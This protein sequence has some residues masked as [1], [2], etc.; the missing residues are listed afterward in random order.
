MQ[1]REDRWHEECE[2]T[3]ALNLVE[4]VECRPTI[5][6]RFAWIP[7]HKRHHGKPVVAVENGKPLEPVPGS[8]C[9]IA[10]RPALTQVVN[11]W[12]TSNGA[13]VPRKCVVGTGDWFIADTHPAPILHHQRLR[14][15][16]EAGTLTGAAG[17][18]RMKGGA[19]KGVR[20]GAGRIAGRPR[21]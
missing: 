16:R 4:Q 21:A 15:L 2:Q 8:P 19:S 7:Y 20:P 3:P 6:I 12:N 18:T 5:R 17:I 11:V 9:N 14:Q 13:R 10:A 1:W